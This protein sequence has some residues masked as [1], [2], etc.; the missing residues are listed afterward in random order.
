M[1]SKSFRK[2]GQSVKALTLSS[3]VG[4]K[5]QSKGYALFIAILTVLLLTFIVLILVALVKVIA[6]ALNA[7]QIAV[8]AVVVAFTFGYMMFGG[9]NSMVYTNTVQAIIMV[10]VA[11]MMI[12]SGNNLFAEGLDG[13]AAKL[14]AIDPNL[15]KTF[16][17]T[18][19]LY[20]DFFL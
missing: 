3:W 13:F 6:Q 11:L 8:L 16:N 4:S 10:I 15:T 12:F 1:L 7:N 19:P 14:N 5:Y 2:F 9:A 20:R 18:S 17:E